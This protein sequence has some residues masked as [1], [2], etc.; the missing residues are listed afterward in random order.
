MWGGALSN[1]QGG[2][3]HVTALWLYVGEGQRGDSAAAW[4]LEFYLEGTSL[5]AFTLMQVT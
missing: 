3:T 5:S 2:A 4:P 1:Y